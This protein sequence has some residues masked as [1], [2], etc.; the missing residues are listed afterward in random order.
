MEAPLTINTF[1]LFCRYRRKNQVRGLVFRFSRTHS[2]IV[3]IDS[4]FERTNVLVGVMVD[5]FQPF[6][7][8]IKDVQPSTMLHAFRGA[9]GRGAG[10]LDGY[11]SHS[12]TSCCR[13]KRERFLCN[14]A[15]NVVKWRCDGCTST[16]AADKYNSHVPYLGSLQPKLAPNSFLDLRD[17]YIYR[18]RSQSTSDVP[19]LFVQRKI[20]SWPRQRH[21]CLRRI[22]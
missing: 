13:Y 15:S 10:W 18:P 8:K 20:L 7:K 1:K 2:L 3:C 5:T 17:S 6:G 9:C 19:F 12:V 22:A 4:C 14:W 16:S 21:H 11:G